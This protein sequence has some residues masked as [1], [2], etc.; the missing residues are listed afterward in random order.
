[1]NYKITIEFGS[2]LIFDHIPTFDGLLAYAAVR[3]ELGQEGMKSATSLTAEEIEWSNGLIPLRQDERGVFMASWLLW[4]ENAHAQGGVSWKKRFEEK[5]SHL[6]DFGGKRR[7]VKINAGQFKSY[8]VPMTTHSIRQGWFFFQTDDLDR[9]I[10]LFDT[11]IC[12]LGKKRSQGYGDIV[13]YDIRPID[14]DPF[15]GT[16]IRPVPTD[17][18][19]EE[20][21]LMAWRSPYWEP[22]NFAVCRRPYIPAPN[23]V[24]SR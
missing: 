12:G 19:E 2:S 16:V 6:V 1:M 23:E 13:G 18:P 22:S 11:H 7:K 14:Y 10:N 3:E 20:G 15:S 5:H 4:D 17:D 24:P 9:V 21:I 8:N